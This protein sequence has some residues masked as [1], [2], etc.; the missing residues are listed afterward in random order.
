MKHELYQWQKDVFE[1]AKDMVYFLANICCGGGKTLLAILVSL[2]KNIPVIVIA[3]KRLCDQWKEELMEN[4]V[5]EEDIF[6]Y[7][8]VEYSSNKESYIKAAEAWLKN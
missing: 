7:N 6:V 1:K 8:Q 5:A 4:G 2:Y 3:P